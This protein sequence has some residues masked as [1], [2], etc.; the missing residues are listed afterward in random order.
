MKYL[1]TGASGLIG[2]N[3]LNVLPVYERIGTYH[4]YKLDNC[5][6]LDIRNKQGVENLILENNVKI[7]F[8]AAAF[9]N[10]DRC[11]VYKQK[12]LDINYRGTINIIR[13][14]NNN[15]AKIIYFSTDYIFD[16]KN[17]PYKEDDLPNPINQYGLSKLLAENAIQKYCDDYLIIRTTVVYGHE[18][19]GKNFVIRMLDNLNKNQTITVPN[20]Q[21]GTPT[22]VQDLIKTVLV[23][24]EKR[25]HG[26][27]N[28]VGADLIDRYSFACLVADV[29]G[30]DKSLIT[31]TT[32]KKNSQKAPRPLNAGLINTKVIS[33]TNVLLNSPG[34]G[35][36]NMLEK[37]IDWKNINE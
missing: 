9:A 7:I 14:A 5:I 27:F 10:V 36:R 17:G 3:L 20:D 4:K 12:C 25:E 31:P 1:V 11:E 29:Y 35:V 30:L 22:Y 28:V 18:I 26:I 16:G 32:T 34:N 15:N 19:Q 8:H 6:Q 13:A 37:K 23:L 33:K 21:V 2:L 24:L